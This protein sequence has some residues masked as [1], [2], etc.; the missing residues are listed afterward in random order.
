MGEEMSKGNVDERWR[1]RKEN[2]KKDKLVKPK[3]SKRTEVN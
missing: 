1:E 2:N 3:S